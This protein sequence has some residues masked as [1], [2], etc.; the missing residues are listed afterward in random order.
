E[1]S[2][3]I[4][5][6]GH[7][8]S[9][10]S[11]QSST[12]TIETSLAYASKPD[13][14]TNAQFGGIGYPNFGTTAQNPASLRYAAM[15]Y[16]DAGCGYHVWEGTA[17]RGN[18]VPDIESDNFNLRI[19]NGNVCQINFD[20]DAVNV[21]VEPGGRLELMSGSTLNLDTVWLKSDASGY[22]QFLG[23][24]TY[25]AIFERSINSSGWH[26][27]SVPLTGGDFSQIE[28]EVLVNYAGNP[29]NPSAFVWDPVTANYVAVSSNA[30]VVNGKGFNFY[31]SDDFVKNGKGINGDGKLPVKLTFKGNLVNGM[32]SN[33]LGLGTASD[34]TG[35]PTGWNMLYN[36]YPC[37]IDLDQLFNGM[38]ANYQIGAHV[39]NPATGTFEIRA[40]TAIN[41]GNATT[42]APGQA[43]FVKLDAGADVNS[44]FYDFGNSVKTIS[45][46]SPLYK[47]QN[48]WIKINVASKSDT[49][50]GFV[51]LDE[52]GTHYYNEHADVSV[53]A[54]DSTQLKLSIIKQGNS[55]SRN[56]GIAKF[57]RDVKEIPLRIQPQGGVV[58]IRIEKNLVGKE[59]YLKNRL[60]NTTSILPGGRCVQISVEETDQFSLILADD[61][62]EKGTPLAKARIENGFLRLFYETDFQFST[63]A[64]L[65]SI[66]GQELFKSQKQLAHQKVEWYIGDLAPGVYLIVLNEGGVVNSIKI[67]MQ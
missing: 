34:A 28:K 48:E 61:Y 46:V 64:S 9:H 19:H 30:D 37:S 60:K 11:W 22:A 50:R 25:P 5:G 49:V 2:D 17:W 63:Q 35:D 8:I 56:L 67:T 31:V 62:P 7:Q 23:D 66:S 44:G 13:F 1:G 29:N 16:I 38:P 15:N 24:I 6:S 39:F 58:S 33:S 57:D 43:L 40:T 45:S 52:S 12:G 65:F 55:K 21:E 54:I 59:F 32:I 3:G 4:S 42:I 18:F 20:V 14:L 27:L 36:P 51:Y 53:M 10:N 26:F 47:N 41:N